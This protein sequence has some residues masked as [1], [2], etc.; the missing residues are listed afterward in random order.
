MDDKEVLENMRRERSGSEHES[1]DGSFVNCSDSDLE[2]QENRSPGR[3]RQMEAKYQELKSNCDAEENRLRNLRRVTASLEQEIDQLRTHLGDLQVQ[4]RQKVD[5]KPASTSQPKSRMV[6]TIPG[7]K[8][9]HVKDCY[10]FTED[11]A[12]RRG[13]EICARC[14]NKKSIQKSDKYCHAIIV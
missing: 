7:S 2:E 11:E 14:A 8:V 6:R 12:E 4:D 3:I 9:F 5:V 13:L 10:F 1:N